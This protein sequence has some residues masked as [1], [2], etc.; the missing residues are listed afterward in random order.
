MSSSLAKKKCVP[1]EGGVKPMTPE[2]AIKLMPELDPEWALIDEAHLLAR[3]F[4]FKDFKQTMAFV[5]KVAEIAEEEGHH[6]DMTVS[7]SDVGIE[8]TTHAIEGLS[9]NDFIVAAKIDEIGK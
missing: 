5:N 9:E 6:P 7:Y 4:H 8:L 1:C 3:S 2:E